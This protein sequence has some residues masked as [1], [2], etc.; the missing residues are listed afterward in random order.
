MEL[1]RLLDSSLLATIIL[2]LVSFSKFSG[3]P[4]FE[5]LITDGTTLTCTLAQW[6]SSSRL[7]K[8]VEGWD[9]G[10]MQ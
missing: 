8:R 3:E 6:H 1:T 2:A 10:K 9:L 7:N 5:Q 4:H